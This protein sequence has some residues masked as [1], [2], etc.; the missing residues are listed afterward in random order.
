MLLEHLFR[1]LCP[2]G[3]HVR[4]TQ[5]PLQPLQSILNLVSFVAQRV[6]LALLLNGAA[7]MLQGI[8]SER[9]LLFQ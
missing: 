1:A 8:T 2:G 7:V 9:V 5:I 3:S 6:L 4:Q